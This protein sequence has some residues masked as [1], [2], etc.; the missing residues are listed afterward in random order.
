MKKALYGLAF[1]VGAIAGAG[2]AHAETNQA[3]ICVQD[4]TYED[5][6][7]GGPYYAVSL[8]IDDYCYD[9][10][11]DPMVVLNNIPGQFYVITSYG[12][13]FD[14]YLLSREVIPIQVM[15]SEGNVTSFTWTV[16]HS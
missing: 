13:D 3:P 9:P 1:A 7:I 5:H 11:G 15:D 14:F 8:Y 10:E 12:A 4:A 16:T 2:S 6:Q